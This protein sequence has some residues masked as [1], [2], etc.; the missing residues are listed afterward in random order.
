MADKLSAMPRVPFRLLLASL[1]AGALAVAGF[2]PFGLWPLPVLSLA[3]LFG[4]LSRVH[5]RRSGFVIG[6]AWGLGFFIAGVSWVF[7]SLSVYDGM[8]GGARN[9]PVLRPAGA[10]SGSRRP[11]SGALAHPADAAIAAAD[12]AR[13]GGDGV[14]ARLAVHRLSLARDGLFAGA[15]Q[16][17][18]GLRAACRRVRGVLPAGVDR[19][20][21]GLDRDDARTAGSADLG[22]GGDRRAGSRRPGLARGRL[23]DAGRYA[24]FGGTG[25]GQHP[26]GNEMATRENP[27]H[28][29]GLRAHDRR[30]ARAA[31]RAAG[32]SPAAV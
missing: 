22:R 1:L 24:H 12:P 27:R 26:A 18:G 4:L 9:L 16:P 14:G 19:G 15:R 23:D 31:H 25:A 17:A 29:G 11:A 28:A 5:S 8:A 13:V 30:L 21:A 20:P 32:N 10:V 6:L 2:A 3:V 7:V